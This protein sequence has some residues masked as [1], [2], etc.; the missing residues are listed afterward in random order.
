MQD[1]HFIAV[2]WR[3]LGQIHILT[4]REQKL[5]ELQRD[6]AAAAGVLAIAGATVA[7]TLMYS[8]VRGSEC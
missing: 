2:S 3:E 8:A 4:S 1:S 5:L 6:S 7:I